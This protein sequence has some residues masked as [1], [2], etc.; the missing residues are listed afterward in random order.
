LKQFNGWQKNNPD[1]RIIS[2]TEQVDSQRNP[3]AS[4]Y[5]ITWTQ[6][7]PEKPEL[8]TFS[9]IEVSMYD[10]QEC[11]KKLNEVQQKNTKIV[12]ITTHHTS[13]IAAGGFFITSIK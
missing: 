3:T 4:G 8:M 10:P 9:Y 5:W 6:Q 11:I 1:K 2:I 12:C 13:G 7:N